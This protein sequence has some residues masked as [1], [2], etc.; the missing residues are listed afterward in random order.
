VEVIGFIEKKL[1]GA[2]FESKDIALLHCHDLEYH[3]C[4]D[5][6][7]NHVIQSLKQSVNS[8]TQPFG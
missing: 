1:Q 2:K 3:A 4:M 7:G 6:V 5:F 8:V